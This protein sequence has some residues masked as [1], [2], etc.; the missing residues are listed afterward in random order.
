MGFLIAFS[1]FAFGGT[2]AWSQLVIVLIASLIVLLVSLRPLVDREFS[3][4][5]HWIWLPLATLVLLGTTQIVPL[6]ASIVAWLSPERIA[7]F[8]EVD[9]ASVP[10]TLTTSVSPL[11]TRHSL[12]LAG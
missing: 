5:P 3:L 10:D 1:V 2:E 12:R 4:R 7:S 9:A 8:G 11:V 6:P